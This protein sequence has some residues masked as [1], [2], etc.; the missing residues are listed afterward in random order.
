M[1]MLFDTLWSWPSCVSFKV[2][3]FDM[4]ITVINDT[5]EVLKVR[6]EWDLNRGFSDNLAQCSSSCAIIILDSGLKF[7]RLKLNMIFTIF[8]CYLSS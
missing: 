6:P 2:M 7:E 5:R 1:L 4:I 3:M 8:E